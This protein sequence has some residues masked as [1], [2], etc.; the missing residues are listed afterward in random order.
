MDV[1]SR[2]KKGGR[3]GGEIAPEKSRGGSRARQTEDSGKKEAREPMKGG[4]IR[5]LV[6]VPSITAAFFPT[7][8]RGYR[9]TRRT[10]RGGLEMRGVTAYNA[11]GGGPALERRAPRNNVEEA[12]A[13]LSRDNDVASA[14][15]PGEGC[16]RGDFAGRERRPR[17]LTR[18]SAEAFFSIKC[19]FLRKRAR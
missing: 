5:T 3:P 16:A 17:S 13:A 18:P 19:S 6:S 11:R 4:A 9:Y 2:G 12:A 1:K 14:Q 8:L 15:W 10:R 7:G